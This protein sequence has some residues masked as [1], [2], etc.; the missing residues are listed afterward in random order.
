MKL[1]F[2]SI[3]GL[4]FIGCII[5]S[6]SPTQNSQQ[7][8]ESSSSEMSSS[9]YTIPS[10]PFTVSLFNLNN[11]LLEDVSIDSIVTMVLSTEGE[12]RFVDDAIEKSIT[13]DRY[14]TSVELLTE[15]RFNIEV[16]VYS[17]N[18]VVGVAT[19]SS[20]F[21]QEYSDPISL[22]LGLIYGNLEQVNKGIPKV[23][24]DV[25]S[26]SDEESYEESS[27]SYAEE[28]SDWDEDEESSVEE[29]SY[30]DSSEEPESE[31]SDLSY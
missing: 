30:A 11:V 17:D 7:V 20:V 3:I 4:F 1:Y 31:S 24:E 5:D 29:G 21:V 12:E 13:D 18:Y 16:S 22:T 25:V 10:I 26:S 28:E 2:L 15:A 23:E 8:E 27:S 9:S 6:N 14:S 19:K